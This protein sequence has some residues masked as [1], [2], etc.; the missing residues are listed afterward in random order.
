LERKA[1]LNADGSRRQK[2]AD[3]HSY[4]VASVEKQ[5]IARLELTLHGVAASN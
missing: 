3:R 4:A 5:R 1:D 2:I